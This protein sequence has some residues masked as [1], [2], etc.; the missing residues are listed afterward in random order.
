MQYGCCC[1]FVK[2]I[3]YNL[4]AL[5]AYLVENLIET[6]DLSVI[7]HTYSDHVYF[8]GKGKG[9]FYLT[10]VVPSVYRTGIN[11]SRR[12]ALYPLPLSVLGFTGI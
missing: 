2:T 12:C 5:K 4:T 1:Y 7:A 8:E 9:N 11:G 6:K 3:Y 10:S